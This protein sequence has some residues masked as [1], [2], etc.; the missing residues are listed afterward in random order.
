MLGCAVLLATNLDGSAGKS[1]VLRAPVAMAWL[2]GGEWEPCDGVKT[3]DDILKTASGLGDLRC[4]HSV[5]P[6]GVC[7]PCACT[8]KKMPHCRVNQKRKDKKRQ[9][10]ASERVNE[11]APYEQRTAPQRAMFRRSAAKKYFGAPVDPNSGNVPV[12]ISRT[13][14]FLN[15][16]EQPLSPLC[17]TAARKVRKTNEQ[18]HAHACTVGVCEQTCRSRGCFA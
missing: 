10:R 5:I 9:N 15:Q 2:A 14:D 7:F 6:S 18:T 4:D 8:Q 17:S 12:L 11:S 16:R 3:I 1:C 13:V